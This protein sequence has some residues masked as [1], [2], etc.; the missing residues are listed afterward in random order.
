MEQLAPLVRDTLQMLTNTNMKLEAQRHVL[1]LF[2]V[3]LRLFRDCLDLFEYEKSHIE[4]DRKWSPS[5]LTFLLWQPAFTDEKRRLAEQELNSKLIEYALYKSHVFDWLITHIVPDI[6]RET[7]ARVMVRLCL[8]SWIQINIE[9]SSLYII[10]ISIL[11]YM[12]GGFPCLMLWL[13]KYRTFGF[14]PQGSLELS[15]PRKRQQQ[16]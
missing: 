6:R 4:V 5:L 7:E 8:S 10:V 15:I 11:L 2:H 9:V 14:G 12:Y 16:K 3:F 1:N 13:N